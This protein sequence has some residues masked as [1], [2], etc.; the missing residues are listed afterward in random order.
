[1]FRCLRQSNQLENG[2]YDD[3]PDN[4]GDDNDDDLVGNDG[5]QIYERGG[6]K[7]KYEPCVICLECR[8][9]A[10]CIWRRQRARLVSTRGGCRPDYKS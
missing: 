8:R 10:H 3:I 1:M 7:R 9:N 5:N 6:C 2:E 4:R